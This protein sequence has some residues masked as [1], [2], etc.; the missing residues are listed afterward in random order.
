MIAR[1]RKSLDE[2]DQGFTLIELL[3]VMIIIGILAAIA[4]PVFLNQRKS[5]VDSSIKSDLRTVAT[6]IETVIVDTQKNPAS[7]SQAATANAPVVVTPTGT[8]ATAINVTVSSGNLVE[9]KNQ[10]DGGYCLTGW[11]TDGNANT[12]TKGITY[13][14]TAGGLGKACGA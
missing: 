12:K 3:V 13:N 2:K 1:I 5:A 8:G 4:I 14:S 9:Y 6:T 7:V 10:T 11:N